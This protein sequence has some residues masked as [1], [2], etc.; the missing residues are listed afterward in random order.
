MFTFIVIT[1]ITLFCVAI[2]SLIAVGLCIGIANLMIYFI[3]T[4]DL[5]NTLLPSA[6][7]TTV[8]IVMIFNMLKIFMNMGFRNIYEPSDYDDEDEQY[9]DPTPPILT[10]NPVK[11]NWH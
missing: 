8:L 4:L 5:A 3:P 9:D 2:I 1:I 7:L 6:V 11:K 10:K